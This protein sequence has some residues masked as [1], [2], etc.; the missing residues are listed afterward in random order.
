MERTFC[1]T[2]ERHGKTH[3]E[4]TTLWKAGPLR[5]KVVTARY[6][7]WRNDLYTRIT[8]RGAVFL[9]S[10]GGWK[11]NIPWHDIEPAYELNNFDAVH[12]GL[13]QMLKDY[14]D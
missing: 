8:A 1:A 2:E 11:E 14:L 4:T 10:E 12:Q 9:Y 7:Q 6:E 3:T 13:A 5:I